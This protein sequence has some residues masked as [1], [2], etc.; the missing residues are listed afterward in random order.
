MVQ[1]LESHST[2]SIVIVAAVLIWAAASVADEPA[3]IAPGAK[4]PTSHLT[5]PATG[6][7][8]D[9]KADGDYTTYTYTFS[10]LVFFSYQDD[11]A[12]TVTN[13]SGA[14]IWSGTFAQDS[15]ASLSPGEGIYGVSGSRPFSLL[16]G[17]PIAQNVLGYF[18]MNE[19]GLGV[20]TKLLTYMP[21]ASIGGEMFIVFGYH[22]DTSV[23]ITN[24]NTDTVLWAGVLHR[25]E[26]FSYDQQD[27]MP[28]M[29]EASE[30]VSALSYT[31]QGYLIPADDGRWIGT[32]FYGFAGYVGDWIND[33][34]IISLNDANHV[35]V[36]NSDTGAILWEGDLDRGD[37]HNMAVGTGSTP[38]VYFEIET[39]ADVSV[40]IAPFGSWTSNYYH[41]L[42][43]VDTTGRRIGTEFFAT[44]LS[45]GRMDFSS[46][47]DGNLVT[48]TNL[49]SGAVERTATLQAGDHLT[50][51]TA[52]ALY[53][54]E[55]TGQLA[56][57]ESFGGGFGG[58]FVP[59]YYG[60]DLP[61]LE[62]TRSDIDLLIDT[63]AE[64]SVTN[65]GTNHAM[66]VSVALYHGDPERGGRFVVSKELASLPPGQSASELFNIGDP[67]LRDHLQLYAVADPDDVIPEAD[68]NNNTAWRPLETN[69]DQ[70]PPLALTIDAVSGL[71]TNDAGDFVPS[72]FDIT[73]RASNISEAYHA[74]LTATLTLPPGLVLTI[75]G[76]EEHGP[77]VTPAGSAFTTVW[78]VRP[79]AT[80]HGWLPYEIEV[81]GPTVPAKTI[82][83]AVWVPPVPFDA[84]I[85]A[86]WNGACVANAE[87]YVDRGDGYEF[88]DSTGL[89]VPVQV[90]NISLGDRLRARYML[91]VELA[92]KSD[93]LAVDERMFEVWVD[94][95]FW[96][97][98]GEHLGYEITDEQDEYCLVMTRPTFLYNMVVSIDDEADDTFYGEFEEGLQNASRCLY[99]ATDGQVR[100][101]KIAVYDDKEHWGSAD[102]RIHNDDRRPNAWVGA[103]DWEDVWIYEW[104]MGTINMGRRRTA[105]DGQ[106]II[107][108]D[109]ALYYSAITHEFGHY[110][111][112]MYDEYTNGF[113]FEWDSDSWNPGGPDHPFNYGM[114]QSD[115]DGE[116]FSSANDY[117]LSYPLLIPR[118]TITE[119]YA[120]HLESCF[121]WLQERLEG[122]FDEVSIRLPPF[123]WYPD[124][125]IADRSGPVGEWV[126]AATVVIDLRSSKGRALPP[127]ATVRV[128]ANGAPLPGSRVYVDRERTGARIY[129]GITGLDG[130]L[131]GVR[132]HPGD[133]ISVYRSLRGDNLSAQRPLPEGSRGGDVVVAPTRALTGPGMILRGELVPEIDAPTVVLS[134]QADQP[135]AG[136]PT[137]TVYQGESTTDFTLTRVGVTD[138]YTGSFTTPLD[139]VLFDGSG[140]LEIRTESTSRAVSTF[141]VRYRIQPVLAE[142]RTYVETDA[143]LMS[144]PADMVAEDLGAL[145]LQVASAPYAPPGDDRYPVGDMHDI[146]LSSPLGLSDDPALNLYYRPED[147]FGLDETSLGLYGWDETSGTW[148]AVDETVISTADNAVSA[149]VAVPGLY[150]IFATDLSDD[151]VQ[152]GRI[153]DLGAVTG[154][155]QGEIVLSWTATGD[156]GD[157]GTA[158]DYLLRSNSVP[159]THQNWGTSHPVQIFASPAA[160]GEAQTCTVV[161]TD[162]NRLHY[163]ALAAVDEAGNMGPPSNFVGAISSVSDYTFS[164]IAPTFD[165]VVDGAPTL[166]WEALTETPSGGYTVWYGTDETFAVHEEEVVAS[167]TTL[168]LDGLAGG[169]PIFWK[170][171]ADKDGEDVWCNQSYFRFTLASSTP[172]TGGALTDDNIY[173][174]PNPVDIDAGS[175]S[176]RFSLSKDGEVTIRIF[177]VSNKLVAKLAD[178]DAMVAGIEQAVSWNGENDAGDPVANGVYFYVIESSAGER[179]VG[180]IA[181]KR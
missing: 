20:G 178:G 173:A 85:S 148:E 160:A 100:F 109:E 146:A 74:Q 166:E 105:F 59:V 127:A 161:L 133:K 114:M 164:L 88:L 49:N 9:L 52:N 69:D 157:D 32:H 14:E 106:I 13:A 30:P 179:A 58:A 28:L 46:F 104:T 136:D 152:P 113:G 23:T 41:L 107:D 150:A 67:D 110:A 125:Y 21:R 90:H 99:D 71:G 162:E 42:D 145:V 26:H 163:F 103:I 80:E 8:P 62:L 73:L 143:M 75:P 135:L 153:E 86:S 6:I 2:A 181:V 93:H 117:L 147:L 56:G 38:N 64:V 174:Y 66:D 142:S 101:N 169:D 124:G 102:M 84:E 47:T 132:A 12:I 11:T 139:D 65:T 53:H 17:D 16:M 44:A 40:S 10:D 96:L 95:D 155:S 60:L 37:F 141:S 83:R 120:E 158:L 72:P 126:E 171:V 18:A 172:G 108:P 82:R 54:I 81:S 43:L 128:T 131:P 91:H 94:S 76:T 15:F 111:F 176:L 63:V 34:N 68:E 87:I 130:S 149:P 138:T 4:L 48:I 118:W 25:G 1:R 92:A 121:D 3:G 55:S 159:I 61:D 180:K 19:R 167:G 79:D 123:G 156:D 129:L 112:S 134:L 78:T 27:Y 98:D 70:E 170:V 144:I 35:L 33:L 89:G 115:G 97:S 24:L 140:S 57:S 31:D 151:A 36:R 45:G 77:F 165:A 137:A 22:D 29:V 39:D 116:E 7:V 51:T 175:A 119:Q 50:H 168:D 5:I 154:S 177:D 122:Y